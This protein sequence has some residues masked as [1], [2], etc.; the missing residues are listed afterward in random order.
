MRLNP[1]AAAL[2]C[3]CGT[4][5]AFSSQT[6]AIA[7]SG[8]GMRTSTGPIQS[9]AS[10][11]SPDGRSN[12]ASSAHATAGALGVSANAVA[13]GYTT[14]GV[15]DSGAHGGASASAAVTDDFTLT[16]SFINGYLAFQN[17]AAERGGSYLRVNWV[18]HGEFLSSAE[19]GEDWLA[20]AG[21]VGS[22]NA[23]ITVSSALNSDSAI[24]EQ[25]VSRSVSNYGPPSYSYST[26]AGYGVLY[27]PIAAVDSQNIHIQMNAWA[28]VDA[29]AY[30]TNS[31][32]AVDANFGNTLYWAGISGIQFGDGSEADG[33]QITA[34]SSTGFDYVPSAV[35]SVPEVPTAGL[36]FCGLLWVVRRRKSVSPFRF[37]ASVG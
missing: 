31:H 28:G 10:S 7:V 15:G 18:L 23:N 14:P 2:L 22:F 11:G 5:N 36:M 27:V 30:R 13:L 9:A 12:A 16:M 4:V 32:A 6:E 3:A 26:S 17:L 33:V 34:L 8:G 35:S 25:S 37:S 19:P 21:S 29:V 24:I 20:S 1:F